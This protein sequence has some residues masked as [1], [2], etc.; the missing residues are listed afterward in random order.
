MKQTI[1]IPPG[2]IAI[3]DP[4][5]NIVIIEEKKFIPKK[6]DIIHCNHCTTDESILIVDNYTTSHIYVIAQLFKE[7]GSLHIGNYT[8]YISYRPATPEEQQIL[9]DALAKEGKRWNPDTLQLEDIEKDVLLPESI[10]LYRAD[11]SGYGDGLFICF[12]D[13]KQLLGCNASKG[14]FIVFSNNISF[15]KVQCKLIPVKRE[16]LKP[17]DTAICLPIKREIYDISLYDVC[18]VL[19]HD[20]VVCL[21]RGDIFTCE[22]P[23]KDR[24][25]YKV[26]PPLKD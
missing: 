24:N 23:A 14:N 20:K 8:S 3:I 4:K 25:W 11:R 12:N 10:A 18:K 19:D 9:F 17:G 16:D 5:D 13:N 21:I 6:G 26:I 7:Y 22:W 1:P 2:C 15:E